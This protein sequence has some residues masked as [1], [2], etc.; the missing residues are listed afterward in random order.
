MEQKETYGTAQGNGQG[1]NE[2]RRHYSRGIA[3]LKLGRFEEALPEIERALE[4]DPGNERYRL[5]K[6]AVLIGLERFEEAE[7]ELKALY[8]GRQP[9]PLMVG[10]K[11]MSGIGFNGNTN[12][13]KLMINNTINN[14]I[15]KSRVL[16]TRALRI[17]RVLLIK[18]GIMIGK[19]LD[20]AMAKAQ[21]YLGATRARLAKAIN[22]VNSNASGSCNGSNN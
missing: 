11:P 19:S 2:A 9:T 17:V 5:A 3:L 10:S 12:N 15:N 6:L 21:L 14:I 1:L 18:A 22:C 13:V 7:N 16:L 4:L 8:L 20:W